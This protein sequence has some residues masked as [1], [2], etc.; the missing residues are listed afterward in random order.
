MDHPRSFC[1]CPQFQ[2]RGAKMQPN[3][4]FV[5]DRAPRFVLYVLIED[6]VTPE[7]HNPAIQP[8]YVARRMCM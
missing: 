6:D 3:P 7:C 2:F 8:T 5:A 1:D 4:S